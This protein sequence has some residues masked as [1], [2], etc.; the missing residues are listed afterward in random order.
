L[1]FVREELLAY[2]SRLT[3]RCEEKNIPP[4][5]ALGPAATVFGLSPDADIKGSFQTAVKRAGLELTFHDLR[6]VFLNRCRERGISI[7]T[8][9]ALSQHRSLAT[10]LKH[11][12]EVPQG[13]LE[14][15]VK[16]LERPPRPVQA[17]AGPQGADSSR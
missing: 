5:V 10:V 15:A 7:E 6:R 13:D 17:Q 8:A 2:R 9:M 4:P 16:K 12:R 14:E 3:T 1:P 11:Y